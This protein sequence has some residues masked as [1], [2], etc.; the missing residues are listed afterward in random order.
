MKKVGLIAVLAAIICGIAVYLYIGTVEQRIAAAGKK[1]KLEMTNVLV[2]AKEIPPYTEITEEMVKS[3]AVPADYVNPDAAREP[4]EV[5]GLCADGTI[6]EGEMFL[7][8]KLG[9]PEELGASLSYDIPDGMRAMTVSIGRESGVGGYITKG[10]LIDLMLFLAAEY[11]DPEEPDR[12]VT[13]EGTTFRLNGGV[14][15]VVLEAVTVMELGDVTFD[16]ES[17]GLYSS[18]TLVLSPE[19]CLRLYSAMMQAQLNGGEL[20]ATLRQR[21][22]A[23]ESEYGIHSFAGFL[24]RDLPD[25]EEPAREAAEQEELT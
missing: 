22:D 2:A 12:L 11:E 5:L 13:S 25:H 4:E 23:A 15:T 24:H 21:D 17:G 10:D 1:Q 18:L 20:Y 8:S 19:D 3:R 7:T 16:D 14:T 9:T 6:V